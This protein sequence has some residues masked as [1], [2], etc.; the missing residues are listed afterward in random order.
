LKNASDSSL[1]NSAF[2]LSFSIFLSFPAPNPFGDKNSFSFA[3]WILEL[4]DL[5]F[6]SSSSIG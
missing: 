2:Y 3:F 5:K 1:G 6:F 4:D